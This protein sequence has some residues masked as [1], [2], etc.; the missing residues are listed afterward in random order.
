MLPPFRGGAP[1][2]QSCHFGALDDFMEMFRNSTVLARLRLC[3]WRLLSECLLCLPR[4][5]AP[6]MR[7]NEFER[8]HQLGVNH[9]RNG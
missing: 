9:E 3:L 6:E 8:S 7:M 4:S 2:T 5:L 1:A